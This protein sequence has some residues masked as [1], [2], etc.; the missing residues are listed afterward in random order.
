MKELLE[1]P[2]IREQW[3][4]AMSDTGLVEPP[5]KDAGR[6]VWTR[7]IGL[8]L[9]SDASRSLVL[10]KRDLY[11]VYHVVKNY[12][13]VAAVIRIEGVYP[14]EWLDDKYVYYTTDYKDALAY[15]KNHGVSLKVGMKW[16]YV[17]KELINVGIKKQ[18]EVIK[19]RK[20]N[21]DKER[22]ERADA[23]IE[24]EDD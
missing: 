10:L 17:R 8:A 12:G 24:E 21:Y 13:S 23:R 7:A 1:N 14:Y 22:T 15:L 18:F 4:E 11:D 20:N 2:E 16:E 5:I 9:K 6:V 3:R 19:E